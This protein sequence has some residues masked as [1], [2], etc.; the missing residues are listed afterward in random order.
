MSNKPKPAPVQHRIYLVD[1]HQTIRRGLKFLIEQEADLAVC[2]E[3][4]TERDA[5]K[6]ICALRP[7]LAIVDL[8]LKQGSGLNLIRKLRQYCPAVKLLVFTMH[9]DQVHAEQAFKAGAHGFMTKQEHTAKIIGVMRELLGGKEGL[10]SHM[11]A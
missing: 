3:A 5:L 1:D 4:E 9:A 7:A 10:G 6:G 2:G 8:R 11:V